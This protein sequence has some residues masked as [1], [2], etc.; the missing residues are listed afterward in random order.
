[1]M[2]VK[3]NIQ[4][5]FEAVKRKNEVKGKVAALKEKLKK[6]SSDRANKIVLDE[7]EEEK[8]ASEDSGREDGQKYVVSPVPQ[9]DCA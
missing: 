7:V 3:E 5:D 2:K 1:M 4:K 6:N 9:I 8:G